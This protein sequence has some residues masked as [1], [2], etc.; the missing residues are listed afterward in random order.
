MIPEQILLDC[1]RCRARKG[2]E[3]VHLAPADERQARTDRRQRNMPHLIPASGDRRVATEDR[4]RRDL[5]ALAA[6]HSGASFG[7]LDC[8]HEWRRA[9]AEAA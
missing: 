7:C 5:V 9:L 6:Q 4:R 1:P 8:G 3:V 2:A